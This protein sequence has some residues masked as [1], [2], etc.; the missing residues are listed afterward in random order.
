MKRIEELFELVGDVEV[1]AVAAGL[2]TTTGA[3]F[4]LVQTGAVTIV[5][6]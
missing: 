4:E 3:T 6:E 5:I 2:G 1:A